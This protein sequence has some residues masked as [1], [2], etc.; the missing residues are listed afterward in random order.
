MLPRA[1]IFLL[2]LASL[3]LPAQ[4]CAQGAQETSTYH[5]LHFRV[6]D[7]A[8]AAA[9]YA[10][11]M[12]GEQI[13][14]SDFDA[15]RQ[16][17]GVLLIFSPGDRPGVDGSLHEGEIKG[18]AGTVVDHVGFSFTDLEA[19][20]SIYREEGIE[21]LQEPIQVGELFS[22][23]FVEDPW[24]TKIEVMQDPELL[25]L[26]HI[27]VMSQQPED[28]IKWYQSQFGGE[29][30]TFKNIPVLLA[31]SYS[32]VWLIVQGTDKSLAGT[33][34]RSIDHLGFGVPDID[35]A[36]SGYEKNNVEIAAQPRSFGDFKIA[37]VE[38]PDGV[39]IEIV[40]PGSS[41]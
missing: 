8:A 26:H 15:V 25:G 19:M 3:S 12:S 13:K 32:D 9:W 36:M 35:I 27:H 10:K 23:G 18:S 1:L 11:Y 6:P 28:A 5:H 22:Y 14:I 39:L 24:G 20:M 38:S 2:L 34:F 30:T 40:G 31:I 7:T 37:F 16:A 41:Q 4:L 21:I 29:I 33:R 17:N